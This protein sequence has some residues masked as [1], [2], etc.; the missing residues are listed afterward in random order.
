[1]SHCL[2]SPM[3]ALTNKE[4]ELKAH[5]PILNFREFIRQHSLEDGADSADTS[6]SS[7]SEPSEDCP[8]PVIPSEESQNDLQ[9]TQEKG[10]ISP[11]S[12]K[13]LGDIHLASIRL[14]PH[15]PVN[16]LP[17]SLSTNFTWS[18]TSPI[19]VL[20][21]SIEP[22]IRADIKSFNNLPQTIL[23]SSKPT[24]RVRSG[25]QSKAQSLQPVEVECLDGHKVL[26]ICPSLL[27]V[28]E[29]GEQKTEQA[30]Q[31]PNVFEWRPAQELNERNLRRLNELLEAKGEVQKTAGLKGEKGG[32]ESAKF[33]SSDEEE[34][35]HVLLERRLTSKPH[36]Q[37]HSSSAHLSIVP[38]IATS[39]VVDCSPFVNEAKERVDLD[40]PKK[41]TRPIPTLSREPAHPRLPS[42]FD[43]DVVLPLPTDD[44]LLKKMRDKRGFKKISTEV[45][46]SLDRLSTMLS[47]QRKVDFEIQH[48]DPTT[49]ESFSMNK[50]N[51]TDSANEMEAD[52]NIK[53]RRVRYRRKTR[54]IR[55]TL[56]KDERM[57][58][59]RWLHLVDTSS[60]T[61]PNITPE[62]RYHASVLFS[63]YWGS[64]TGKSSSTQ[65]PSGDGFYGEDG[66]IPTGQRRENGDSSKE[67]RKKTKLIAATAMACLTLATKWHFDFCKPLFTVQL[68]SF[69][70]TTNFGSF[71]VTPE[72][73]IMAE[74]A[75]LF[76]YPVAGGLWLDC[77]H[78]FLEELIHIVPTLHILSSIP[79]YILR[80]NHYNVSQSLRYYDEQK[81]LKE[82]D[83]DGVWDWPDV[84]QEFDLALEKVTT[85]QEFLAI[86]P[87]VFCVIALYLA[88]VE[89]EPGY[90]EKC[91]DPDKKKANGPEPPKMTFEERITTTSVQER[92]RQLVIQ[93]NRSELWVWKFIDVNETMNQV[94]EALEVSARD[95]EEC[96]NWYSNTKFPDL[97]SY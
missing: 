8:T 97:N 36:S 6:F 7:Y 34:D 59:I 27:T 15:L 78:A 52:E 9:Q 18:S 82:V 72:N 88:L 87:A 40:L 1:M 47:K 57:L 93:E 2:R 86:S 23:D 80:K 75:I 53:L 90:Y 29:A 65:P 92:L 50:T 19:H 28:K 16:G 63:L 12:R 66:G 76:S 22:V 48:T 62:V 70:Q 56:S 58:G 37:P 32:A 68:K 55:C 35:D 74:R 44:L 30:K 96:L 25:S 46:T 17:T 73:L 89:V 85:V 84:M 5:S 77:P 14:D 81:D 4:H 83:S 13:P 20:E 41:T 33:L 26:T 71:K 31:L 24:T 51:E 95:V 11:Q 10:A 39:P 64:R 79:E 49:D 38:T 61:N 69:C 94:C 60:T 91:R 67:N 3:S 45:K 54:N 42:F 43:S 21:S